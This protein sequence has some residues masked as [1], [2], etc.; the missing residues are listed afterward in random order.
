MAA[1]PT[2][3]PPLPGNFKRKAAVATVNL[4]TAA[5]SSSTLSIATPIHILF[6]KIIIMTIFVRLAVF[7]ELGFRYLNP[8]KI[9]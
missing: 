3:S 6:Y 2:P 4:A 8:L 9:I 5:P 1:P 7:P